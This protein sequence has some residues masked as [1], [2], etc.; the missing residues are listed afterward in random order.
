MGCHLSGRVG[1]AWRWVWK[2]VQEI[3]P[4]LGDWMVDK[5]NMV[6]PVLGHGEHGRK[7]G[8]GHPSPI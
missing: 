3:A 2:D 4:M 8:S 7:E 1:V 6:S 5:Q